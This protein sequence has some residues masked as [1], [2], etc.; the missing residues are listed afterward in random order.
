MKFLTD[1]LRNISGPY[2]VMLMLVCALVLSG[3]GTSY[4]S[5]K[6]PILNQA[7]S[8]PIRFSEKSKNHFQTAGL[9][10]A[11]WT[12]LR[13]PQSRFTNFTGSKIPLHSE[14]NRRLNFGSAD[15]IQNQSGL[16]ATSTIFISANS[17]TIRASRCEPFSL[18]DISK[19]ARL[20]SDASPRQSLKILDAPVERNLKI[21]RSGRPIRLSKPAF[22][23][24]ATGRTLEVLLKPAFSWRE[25]LRRSTRGQQRFAA[26]STG[27][28]SVSARRTKAFSDLTNLSRANLQKKF[29]NRRLPKRFQKT[30]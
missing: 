24:S 21:S 18:N 12:Q 16:S 30:R 5:I 8:S 22:S 23:A 20:C 14:T 29:M 19:T 9:Q 27:K 2:G 13:E 17:P 6:K 4:A 1:T 3:F 10:H 7:K 25:S 28:L 11:Q 15:P 26:N